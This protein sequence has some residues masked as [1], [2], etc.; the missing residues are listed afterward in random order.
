MSDYDSIKGIF[1]RK[2]DLTTEFTRNGFY[3]ESNNDY[4]QAKKCYVD[5]MSH[6]W[7]EQ[8]IPAIEEELWQESLLRCCNELTDW[9]TMCEYATHDTSLKRLFKEDNYTL[10]CVFPY[11]FRSKCKLVL[12]EDVAEQRKHVDL[13]QFVNELEADDKKY[14]EQGFCLEMALISLHQK[15]LNAAKYYAHIAIQNYLNVS[16]FYLI[17][18]I[19]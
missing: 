16:V 9:R 12:Q 1:M 2:A 19:L 10:E 3:H 18:N 11:A 4:Y 13:I 7:G 6:E 8:R 17:E 14:I 15:D 5:A